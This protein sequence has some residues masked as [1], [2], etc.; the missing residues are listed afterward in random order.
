[1]S[2]LHVEQIITQRINGLVNEITQTNR[3]SMRVTVLL[4]GHLDTPVVLDFG[5]ANHDTESPIKMGDWL[6][7]TTQVER[8][9][10]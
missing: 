2:Q 1:M 10:P 5:Q 3:G 4:N 6:T 7:I 9:N 8:L